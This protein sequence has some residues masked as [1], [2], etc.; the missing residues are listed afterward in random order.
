MLVYYFS[1]NCI[2][3]IDYTPCLQFYVIKHPKGTFHLK[4]NTFSH[5]V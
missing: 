2:K 5:S 3:S 4:V 1:I